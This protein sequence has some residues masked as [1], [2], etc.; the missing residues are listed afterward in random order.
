[1]PGDVVY[2][3]RAVANYLIAKAAVKGGLD[4]LQVMKLT[5]ISHGFTLAV[6]GRPLL[7]DDVEAWK[8]GPAI[9]RIYAVLPGGSGR[10]STPLGGTPAALLGSAEKTVVEGVYQTYGSLTGTYLSTLTHR[11]GSPWDQTWRTYGQNAVIPRALIMKHY[12]GVLDEW[13]DAAQNGR[14]YSTEAL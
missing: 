1:M 2:N 12:K 5:Y 10:I 8:F 9:R 7:E 13:R 6:L 11:S 14:V 4:A 3:A